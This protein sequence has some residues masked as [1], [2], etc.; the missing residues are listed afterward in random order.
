M[1]RLEEGYLKI[2]PRCELSHDS[3]F[4]VLLC[5]AT[6]SE[7]S[8][9]RTQ[10][11]EGFEIVW[12]KCSGLKLTQYWEHLRGRLHDHSHAIMGWCCS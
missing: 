3:Q 1:G 7:S 8:Q 4:S 5:K 2:V 12:I 10:E 11:I 9:H 6:S